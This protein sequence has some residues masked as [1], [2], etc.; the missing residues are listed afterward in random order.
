MK[1]GIFDSGI[2]GISVLHEALLRL[3]DQ[4][5]F[6]YADTDHVP[7]GL[8][9]SEEILRY[10]D[11]II[12]D[13]VGRGADAVVIACNTATAVAAE[14]VRQKYDIPIIGME[15]AVKPALR[16]SGSSRVLVMATP[17]TI[18]ENKLHSLLERLDKDHLVDLLE[19][20]DLV[21]FAENEIFED[22]EVDNYIEKRL[23]GLDITNYS[24]V[25]L[26]CTHFNYFKPAIKKAFGSD[27][28]LI[29]GNIGTVNHLADTLGL[30]IKSIERLDE[31]MNGFRD[32]TLYLL[33]G[34]EAGAEEME[35]FA[36]L[37]ARLEKMRKI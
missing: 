21:S 29:D 20:P 1:I 31:E 15:P 7:Y 17:V 23:E 6:F 12:S 11:E 33:S 18:R 34:R 9:S 19:M 14:Y 32:N 2:G 22:E 24:E 26:G 8:R 3:P 10:A 16:S 4:E 5:Y 30:K 36:R 13:L 25:V 28:E 37:H 35:R 27:I